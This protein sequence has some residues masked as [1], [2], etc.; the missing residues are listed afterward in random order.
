MEEGIPFKFSK[1]LTFQY[2][3]WYELWLVS[4]A[5]MQMLTEFQFTTFLVENSSGWYDIKYNYI[6]ISA[7]NKYVSNKSLQ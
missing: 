3:L 4:F 1:V 5:K 6:I 7:N 2:V